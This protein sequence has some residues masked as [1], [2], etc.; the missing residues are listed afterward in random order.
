MGLDMY[1]NA[2]RYLSNYKDADKEKKAEMLKMFPELEVYL[3]EDDNPIREV[4]VEVGYWRKANQIHNWFVQNIQD[5]E[6]DCRSYYVDRKQLE[7]LKNLCRQVLEDKSLA[8][9]LLP[10][11]SGFFFGS[12]DFD[13][14]Y[15][16]DLENTVKI[17][18]NVLAL[19]E[20]WS[21]EYQ[22][23]W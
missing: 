7:Q 12:T 13:D 18:D 2:S 9:E 3:N 21:F 16:S 17:I 22:S 10:T 4:K 1:L 8:D 15:F 5:G 19:P 14:W 11:T 20:D 6:D 23:S